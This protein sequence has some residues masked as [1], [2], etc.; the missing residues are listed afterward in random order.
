MVSA[1]FRLVDSVSRP[2]PRRSF[3]GRLRQRFRGRIAE[4]EQD[5]FGA[6]RFLTAEF[7][8]RL[9]EGGNPE[10]ILSGRAVHAVEECRQVNEFAAGVHEVEVEDLLACHNR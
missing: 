2:R 6:L 8:H 10:I 7:F 3:H 5:L 1:N 4:G 9:A